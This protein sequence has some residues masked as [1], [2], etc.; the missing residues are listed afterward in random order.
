MG[1][2]RKRYAT[3]T[4][5]RKGYSIISVV[6]VRSALARASIAAPSS[7]SVPTGTTSAGLEPIVGRPRRRVLAMSS[8]LLSSLRIPLTR[9]SPQLHQSYDKTD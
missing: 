5:R 3:S 6:V 2:E 7:G 8:G 4:K 1:D 9:Q